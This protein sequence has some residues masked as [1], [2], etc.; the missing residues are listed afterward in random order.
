M[1]TI[2]ISKENKKVKFCK[3]LGD[4]KSSGEN[5][6]MTKMG[7][8]SFSIRTEPLHILCSLNHLQMSY[9]T[10]YHADTKENSCY[11]AFLGDGKKDDCSTDTIFKNGLD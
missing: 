7:K 11:S 6:S 2:F 5:K 3:G 4:K 1:Y 8:R 10:Y 9:K